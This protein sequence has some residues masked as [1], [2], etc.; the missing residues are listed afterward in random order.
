[1][2]RTSDLSHTDNA[3]YHQ[4]HYGYYCVIL[5]LLFCVIS[6]TSF[7]FDHLIHFVMGFYPYQVLNR[8]KPK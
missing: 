2:S 3:L 1:M 6:I 4:Q 5:G 7:E 8:H